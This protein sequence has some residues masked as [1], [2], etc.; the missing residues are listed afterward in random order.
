[1][2]IPTIGNP[3]TAA[4]NR[5]SVRQS[6]ERAGSQPADNEAARSGQARQDEV[7]ISSRAADLQSLERSIRQLPDV[8]RARVDQLREKISNGEYQIDARRLADRIADFEQ[9]LS[10]SNTGNN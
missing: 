9:T 5:S 10:A 1:M 2:S 6:N 7:S 8:D 3:T 4:D